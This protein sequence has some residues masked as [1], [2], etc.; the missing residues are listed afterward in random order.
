[1]IKGKKTQGLIDVHDVLSKTNGGY[2]IFKAY[3]GT[4]GRIMNR[5]WG[6]KERVLSW[7][8][9]SKNGVWFYKD[10]AR[11]DTGN[12]IHFVEKYF[13]LSFKEA[14]EKVA[15]DFGIGGSEIN[16]SPIII[17]WERPDIEKDYCEIDIIE[18]PFEKRHHDFWNILEVSEEHCKKMNTFAVKKA[19]VGKKR[20]SI[21]DTEAVFAYYNETERAFKLYFPDR[22]KEDRFKTNV[23]G[24]HLWNYE[25]ITE[26][27]DLIIQK[28]NKDM[29]VVTMITPC[30]VCTQNESAGI[31]NNEM[32]KKIN[33]ISKSPWVW[34]GSDLDG[35][36]KC[37][38]ITGMNKWKYINT[39]A[40]MLPD[41]NDAAEFVKWHNL[42]N[43]GTGLK[44]LEEF[45]IFKKLLK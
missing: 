27:E 33:K 39:P 42:K 22:P 25:K 2:D 23:S 12:A 31:F 18:M 13:N 45:M 40:D 20:I 36:T 7:G 1:M 43:P 32:V 4:V 15:W 35:V 34:Y 29:N 26:C 38:K 16:K 24:H 6:G 9:F 5:P 3:L 41:V 37:K 21:K 17:N 19:I 10:Q 11:E 14:L 8:I 30:V 28:S 44:K